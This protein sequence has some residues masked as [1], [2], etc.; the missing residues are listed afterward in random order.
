MSDV[1][2]I[3]IA[4]AI[5]RASRWIGATAALI[6]AALLLSVFTGRPLP[7]PA[8]AVLCLS[9]VA[10]GAVTYLMV[11]VELDRSI[12]EAAAGATNLDAFFSGFDQSRLQLGL[13]AAPREA[14]PVAERVRGLL[15]LVQAMGYLFL[16]ELFLGIG[17]AWIARWLF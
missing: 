4:L 10:G 15:R 12:F 14:R 8:L 2:H 3:R 16:A 5:A 11:R 9:I 7:N 6:V 1:D 13:G 17:S